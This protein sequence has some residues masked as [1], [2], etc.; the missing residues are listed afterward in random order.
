VTPSAAWWDELRHSLD[1][2]ASTPTQRIN[3]GQDSITKRV[4]AAFGEAAELPVHEWETVHSDLQWTNLQQ[5]F[6]LIDWELW[7]RGPAGTDVASLYCYSRVFDDV[8]D[9]DRGRTALV[10][11]AARL[12]LRV[13]MGDH[14]DL[15]QPLRRLA[16]PLL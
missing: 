12:L 14:P 11:V 10:H 2:L 13:R 16:G 1:L 6:G 9:A 8:L 4:Q 5:P 3:K 15:E 7:G